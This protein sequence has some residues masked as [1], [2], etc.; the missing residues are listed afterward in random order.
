MAHSFINCYLHGVFSTKGRTN[1]IPA[2]IQN[3]LWN[4]LEGIAQEKNMS[5]LAV[6]GITN[7]VH[8]L[9]SLPATLPISNAMQSIKGSSSKWIHDTF[10][11]M[12]NFAWQEG[13]SAFS[14]S[15]SHL[16]KTIQYINNQAEHHKS[17]SF[18]EELV[19]ILKKHGIQYD[20]RYVWG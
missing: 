2:E 16:Q 17:K 4:Y 14:V 15:I 11:D 3:R 5:V 12:R 1:Q 6:G 9:F 18:E 7:H 20:D 10:S 19:S 13:Y 8:I